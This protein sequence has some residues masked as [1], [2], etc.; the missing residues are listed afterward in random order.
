MKKI[1]LCLV[2]A[3]AHLLPAFGQTPSAVKSG[4]DGI[5]AELDDVHRR[6]REAIARRDRGVIVRRADGQDYRA[7]KV[8]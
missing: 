8:Q 1:F 3:V 2:I 4:G 7:N 6:V 5:R